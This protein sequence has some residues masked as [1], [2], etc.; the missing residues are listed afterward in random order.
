MTG[1]YGLY[2]RLMEG[3]SVDFMWD[4]DERSHITVHE[5][6]ADTNDRNGKTAV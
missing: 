4:V 1:L 3:T 6:S 5:G 2:K